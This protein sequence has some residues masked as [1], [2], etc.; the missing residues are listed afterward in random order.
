MF[1][2]VILP[3]TRYRSHIY[4]TV[5]CSS[6]TFKGVFP[7]KFM[8]NVFRDLVKTCLYSCILFYVLLIDILFNKGVNVFSGIH[9]FW[10]NS[11][12]FRWHLERNQK[13]ISESFHSYVKS[14]T[15][16]RDI[17]RSIKG[18]QLYEA[19]QVYTS[20]IPPAI[21]LLGGIYRNH[22]LSVHISRKCNS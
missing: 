5:K 10:L 13:T 20:F 3:L 12:F 16:Y 2:P 19:I 18:N 7:Q 11:F 22:R 14:C 17:D 15:Y 21:N 4:I 1:H 8:L 6:E 9:F